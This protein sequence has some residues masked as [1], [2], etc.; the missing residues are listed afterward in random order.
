[1]A[2]LGKPWAIRRT[3]SYVAHVSRFE[4]GEN[5]RTCTCSLS[6]GDKPTLSEGCASPLAQWDPTD[7]LRVARHLDEAHA[8]VDGLAHGRRLQR[9]DAGPEVEARVRR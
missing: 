9:C 7:E 2:P 8:A 6:P 3:T 4:D 1:M 5:P